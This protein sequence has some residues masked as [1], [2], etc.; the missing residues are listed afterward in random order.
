MLRCHCDLIPIRRSLAASPFLPHYSPF[1]LKETPDLH[2]RRPKEASYVDLK[3]HS[4]IVEPIL[5]NNSSML[6]EHDTVVDPGRFRCRRLLIQ[7]PGQR[8]G[9]NGASEVKAHP[10][11]KMVDW[12]NLALQKA[13]FVP[14][15]DTDDDTS[16][17]LSRYS[18]SSIHVPEDL[19]SSDCVSDA[20]ESSSHNGNDSNDVDQNGE[21]RDLVSSSAVDLS[22]INF[23]FKSII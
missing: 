12:D 18:S 5:P 8:L 11:F 16:Y 15:P 19:N 2:S 13:A 21:W 23:S 10:F 9:A 14:N 17:F 20:T 6:D 7:D 1:S 4:F 3:F 22:S